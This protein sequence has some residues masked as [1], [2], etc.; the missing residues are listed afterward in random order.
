MAKLTLYEKKNFSKP[1]K[2]KSG[3]NTYSNQL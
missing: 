1:E 2:A 3:Y